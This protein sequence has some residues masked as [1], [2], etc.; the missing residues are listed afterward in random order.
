MRI[1]LLLIP[2]ALT[3][4]GSDGTVGSDPG[5]TTAQPAPAPVAAPPQAPPGAADPPSSPS[6]SSPG[7]NS[8]NTG[9]PA[10]V[11]TPPPVISP[12]VAA[13]P[14]PISP[15]EGIWTGQTF[16]TTSGYPGFIVD[17]NG[18]YWSED[19]N[20]FCADDA[21]I[22]GS[23]PDTV[24]QGGLLDE[25]CD[26]VGDKLTLSSASVLQGSL[27]LSGT[28]SDGNWCEDGDGKFGVCGLPDQSYAWAESYTLE[29]ATTPIAI[30]ALAGSYTTTYY[31]LL[32]IH[33]DGTF[34]IAD[35]ISQNPNSGDNQTNCLYTGTITILDSTQNIYS[36]SA[37]VSSLP[38]GAPC[39]DNIPNDTAV[40]VFTLLPSGQLAGGLGNTRGAFVTFDTVVPES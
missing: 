5:D 13:A 8:G 27:S 39:A 23:L 10:P 11:T 30:S 32:T 36:L 19:A 29:V 2:L 4:C 28:I 18:V 16:S 7:G 26:G 17:A 33:A 15:Y 22:T 3:A 37:T 21:A 40:G 38:S 12:P 20:W 25:V 6:T 14:A 24:S 35:N 34:S 1:L 31:D 9:P